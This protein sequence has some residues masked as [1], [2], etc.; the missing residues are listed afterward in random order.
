MS[1]HLNR[2]NDTKEAEQS[3][4]CSASFIM[5]GMRTHRRNPRQS[6]I[7]DNQQEIKGIR[8]TRVQIAQ[9]SNS[10]AAVREKPR[11]RN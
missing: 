11:V 1:L 3:K 9:P 8:G 7:I 2:A 10:T 6:L 5:V 4:D